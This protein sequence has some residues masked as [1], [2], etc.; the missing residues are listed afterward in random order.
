M[1]NA[2]IGCGLFVVMSV[3]IFLV[4]PEKTAGS[5]LGYAFLFGLVCSIVSLAV[6][7]FEDYKWFA[8][9]GS[10]ILA[11]LLA[12]AA[13]IKV[14]NP[15]SRAEMRQARPAAKK[16]TTAGKAGKKA[17]AGKKGGASAVGSNVPQK[18][19]QPPRRTLEQAL[20][21]LDGMIGLK[22]VK[23]EIHKLVDYTKIVQ[24]RKKHVTV[25][26]SIPTC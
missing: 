18:P 1:K 17:D 16:K 23:A 10:W 13:P 22:E 26:S 7:R 6:K 4:L 9:G 15:K 2:G 3:I 25:T 5:A 20:A 8:W 19:A 11:S 21:E 14:D 12:F 24:A